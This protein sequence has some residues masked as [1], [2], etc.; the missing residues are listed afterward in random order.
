[1]SSDQG[2]TPRVSQGATGRTPPG[3]QGA[4]RG[5][6]QPDSAPDD[7]ERRSS[8]DPNAA[9]DRGRSAGGA[10]FGGYP[11]TGSR[12]ERSSGGW[13]SKF[14]DAKFLGLPVGLI[15][16]LGAALI[17]IVFVGAVCG[18]PTA[19]G[20]VAGQVKQLNADR[21]VSTLA[22]AELTLRGGGQTYTT[23][24]TDVDPNAEGDAA[25][26]YRFENV[27]PGNYAL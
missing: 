16:A 12:S 11:F 17:A 26:N 21:T 1:M 3:A 24:S 18:K 10:P 9:Y 20:S 8:Y 5:G 14:G 15:Y 13:W 7:G 19:T 22:G 2:E 4:S 6:V 23:T 25:Y 27:P